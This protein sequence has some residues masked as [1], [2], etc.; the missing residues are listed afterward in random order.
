MKEEAMTQVWKF[1]LPILDVVD[2]TVPEGAVPLCVQ[3]QDDIPC[4]WARVD[5]DARVGAMRLRIAGTGHYLEQNVGD[6][7]DSFQMHGGALVLHVFRM[8][9]EG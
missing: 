3:V 8:P 9:Q 2:L 7:I 1:P 6:Y 4:L 5:P